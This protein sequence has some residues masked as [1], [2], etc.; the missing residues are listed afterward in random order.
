MQI[1]KETK[2]KLERLS[3]SLHYRW[4]LEQKDYYVNHL[5]MCNILKQDCFVVFV[6]HIEKDFKSQQ[7]ITQCSGTELLYLVRIF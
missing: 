6:I 4:T 2:L 5:I 1:E 7:Q 3:E